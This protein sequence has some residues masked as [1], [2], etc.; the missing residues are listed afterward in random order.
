MAKEE[1]SK[2]EKVPEKKEQK[3]EAK[4]RIKI[5]S[6]KS[7]EPKEEL[8][9]FQSKWAM[10]VDRKDEPVRKPKLELTLDS[11]KIENLEQDIKKV[12]AQK[13]KGPR[14]DYDITPKYE[15]NKYNEVVGEYENPEKEGV[16]VRTDSKTDD[17]LDLMR[18]DN[19]RLQKYEA[20]H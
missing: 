8:V 11:E 13:K 9:T 3:E 18:N 5:V 2:S 4:E 17:R 14:G 19:L 15:Q 7:V 20:K 10:L 1:K 12:S 6:L 16:K